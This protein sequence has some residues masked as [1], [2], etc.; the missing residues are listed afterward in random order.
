MAQVLRKSFVLERMQ[1]EGW[2]PAQASDRGIVLSKAG[3][4]PLPI[5][6]H[7]TRPDLIYLKDLTERV[8]VLRREFSD[9]AFEELPVGDFGFE[10]LIVP[11][12]AAATDIQELFGALSEL[13]SALGGSGL[14]IDRQEARTVTV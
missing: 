13:D 5:P 2:S 14:T 11:G 4:T 8:P 6:L 1:R 7:P 3:R 12:Q 10:I 9:A